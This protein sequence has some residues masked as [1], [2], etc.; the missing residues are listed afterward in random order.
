[1]SIL[2]V[3]NIVCRSVNTFKCRK[4]CCIDIIFNISKKVFHYM[5]L[6]RKFS[7]KKLICTEYQTDFI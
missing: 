7:I 4:Q 3:S 2:K 1:M 6:T 5:I